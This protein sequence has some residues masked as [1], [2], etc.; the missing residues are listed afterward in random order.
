MAPEA[1]PAP[2]R[3]TLT[4]IA[5]D[6]GF[7]VD[8]VIVTARIPV[9]VDRLEPGPRSHRFHVVD[10][11]ATTGELRP[12]V[13]LGDPAIEPPEHPWTCLDD[14]EPDDTFPTQ[15]AKD[16]Y[17][18]RLVE[19]SRFRAQNV[20][21]I[22]TRTLAAFEFA[23]GRRVDWAFDSHQL[24]LVPQAFVEANA[25]YAR[26]DRGL[27][28]GY[29]PREDGPAVYTSLS[30]DIVCHETTHAILDGLRPRF[31]EPSLPDQP[32]FH[33]ALGDIVAL[34]S[35]FSLPEAVAASL[36]HQTDANR[37][38]STGSLADQ[39]ARAENVLFGV[40]EQFGEA[41][42]GVRGSALRRSLADPCHR[43]WREH[44]SYEEPHRRGE[45][46]VAAIMEALVAIWI[47]RL[48]A[49][50][51]ENVVKDVLAAE[52]GAKAA[53][54]L[55]TMVIR[56]LDYQPAV[57]LEFD[58]VLDAILTADEVTAPEDRHDYRG[59]LVE[60]FRQF[61]IERPAG[62][63]V[64]VAAGGMPLRYDQ[65]NAQALRTSTKEAYRFIWHN[66]EALGLSSQW[67][68]QVEAV[69]PV[70]RIGPDGLIVSE[71]VVDYVQVLECT[72]AQ[73]RG[74]HEELEVPASL[75]DDVALQMWGGGTLIFDQF[76]RLKLHQRKDLEDWRRQSRRLD[77]L[78]RK[79]LFDTRG[80][81]GFSTGA[82][83]GMAFADLHAP[84]AAAGEGW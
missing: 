49:L 53:E 15:A 26:E 11:N 55:L 14:F 22:A 38:I 47:R 59:A 20:F 46:L 80:R 63:M 81:L 35:V 52:E 79:G 7:M 8:G 30:H 9:P 12:D 58:D 32:A 44:A 73:A 42:S 36:A 56:S 57:E 69:R 72:A 39:T 4:V 70:I 2:R 82:A 45:V 21:A 84:D 43:E 24:Y 23:L 74:L 6:P 31:L 76:G 19:D 25:H 1:R 13:D 27:F 16:A 60:A 61:G 29:L 18:R 83:V 65:L 17:N 51:Y 66:R 10:Y 50:R 33:E 5:Q 62:R 3:R 67:H 75:G 78:V 37:R 77:H 40:A 48:D 64:D 71:I 54:H 41:L 68:L 28:F 34:L